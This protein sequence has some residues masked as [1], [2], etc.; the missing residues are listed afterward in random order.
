[1]ENAPESREQEKKLYIIKLVITEE[2]L[3][4]LTRAVGYTCKRNGRKTRRPVN[5]MVELEMGITEER[6]IAVAK[7]IGFMSRVQVEQAIQEG[8]AKTAHDLVR[9]HLPIDLRG[10]LR[11]R[12]RQYITEAM[13]Q[14]KG[15]KTAAARLLG[16]K[17]TTIVEYLRRASAAGQP[18]DFMAQP[19]AVA[20]SEPA[21]QPEPELPPFLAAERAYL[22][23]AF[24]ASQG[25]MAAAANFTGFSPK[26]LAEKAERFGIVPSTFAPPDED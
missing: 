20:S 4:E 1:M 16:L 26:Q 5:K 2:R 13:L 25:N 10:Q 12:E 11:K 23:A 8:A 9:P 22:I 14:A 3:L 24:T 18:I 15:N 6:M 7:E 21:T 17:R 19:D